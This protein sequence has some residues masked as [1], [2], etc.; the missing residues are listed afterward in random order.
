[1]ADVVGVGLNAT[2]TLLEIPRF[3][4]PEGKVEVAA[5][6]VL[7]GGQ[8]ASAI[9]ACATWGLKTRYVGKIGDD[10]AAEMQG[11]E[12]THAGVEAHWRIAPCCASQ[13]SWIL[14][15]RRSGERS[16]LWKRDPKLRLRPGEL[17][18]EWITQA[19]ILLVD[20]HDTAAATQ[21]AR[22]ARDAGIP[23]VADIDDLYPGVEVLLEYVDFLVGPHEFPARLFHSIELLPAL[24]N[25]ARRFGCKI[26]GATL[27]KHGVVAWDGG[28][29]HY[30][31]AY[32]VRAVDTT[33]A[34]DI[35]HGAMVYALIQKW[36]VP[37]MLDFCCAAAA[38]NCTAL[39]ARGGIRPIRDIQNLMKSGRQRGSIVQ[40][41]KFP[42]C[43]ASKFSKPFK[44]MLEDRLRSLA[45]R[46]GSE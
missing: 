13:R 11:A 22:W 10:K 44:V 2:D 37:K 1:M 19:R 24:Q 7:P 36:S 6:H 46:R 25:I 40:A 45:S 38:L 33:G 29:F 15:D 34:G 23:V 35:F 8:V 26:V 9:Q 30:S 12:L 14:V 28:S 5:S 32:K 41:R 21:A 42:S 16:V 27:G 17:H 39:G 31:P 4:T 18:R 20:G 43:D 3:P